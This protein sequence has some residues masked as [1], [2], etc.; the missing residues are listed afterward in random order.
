MSNYN[1]TLIVWSQNTIRILNETMKICL[2]MILQGV[3]FMHNC[4]ESVI[5][6]FETKWISNILRQN[7]EP[8][9]G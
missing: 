3:T 8:A 7:V 5:K 1:N 6:Q 4:T 9:I 2:V